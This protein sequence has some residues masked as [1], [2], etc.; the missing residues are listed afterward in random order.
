M[1]ISNTATTAMMMPIAQAVLTQLRDNLQAAT[2]GDPG[3]S[4]ITSDQNASQSQTGA[5]S[6]RSQTTGRDY[7]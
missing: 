2:S 6:Y 5:P 7:R 3:V 1:W 4:T